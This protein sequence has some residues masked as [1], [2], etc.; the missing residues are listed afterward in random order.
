M[1][2]PAFALHT[3]PLR[4]KFYRPKPVLRIRSRN[5]ALAEISLAASRLWRD[6]IRGECVFDEDC[7]CGERASAR[8]ALGLADYV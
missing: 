2:L 7:I 4:R 3:E 1:D 5:R 8:L 6:F